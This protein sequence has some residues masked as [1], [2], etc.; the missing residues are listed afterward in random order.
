MNKISEYLAS[1]N[2]TK[3]FEEER[4][5]DAFDLITFLSDL[6]LKLKY[7]KSGSTGHTFMAYNQD[8]SCALKIVTYSKKKQKHYGNIFN[9]QRPENVDIYM[10][11]QLNKIKNFTHIPRF[12]GV[13]YT[14]TS[15]FENINLDSKKI[16]ELKENIDKGKIDPVCSVLISEYCKL[17]DLQDYISENLNTIDSTH[18]SVIF[19]QLILSLVV[20]NHHFNNFKHNDLK[21]NN[22]LLQENDNNSPYID[23]KIG[24]IMYRIPNLGFYLKIWDFD[25]SSG[26]CTNL[27]VKQSW[28]QKLNINDTKNSYYDLHFFFNNLIHLIPDLIDPDRKRFDEDIYDFIDY[29]IPKLYR[30]NLPKNQNK[31]NLRLDI[32]HEYT[33]PLI[34]LSHNIFKKYTYF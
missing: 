25:F 31:K 9:N 27:K 20:M 24:K 8:T 21:C 33:T 14:C 34:A 17:G 11:Q 19:F 26:P 29:V 15:I 3:S 28:A 12:Y 22:I 18:L 6:N 30:S 4:K 7:I 16:I 13:F 10:L 23:Y 5:Y 2:L 1:K 32:N